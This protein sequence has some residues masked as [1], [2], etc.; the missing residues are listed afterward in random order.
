MLKI[1]SEP[2]VRNTNE[3]F[4]IVVYAMSKVLQRDRRVCFSYI[5]IISNQILKVNKK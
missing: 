5:N 3:N 4:E 1:G 2:V